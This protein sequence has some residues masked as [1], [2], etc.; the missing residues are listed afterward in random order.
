MRAM[1]RNNMTNLGLTL[2]PAVC[3]FDV[4]GVLIDSNHA[5][6]QAM[7]EAFSDD[8]V[9]KKRTAQQYLTLTG[10]DRGT[11]IRTLQQE[12]TSVQ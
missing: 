5:N 6:A 3:I 4:N 10:I 2:K 7:A 9:V 11:K 12:V 8:P 1:L